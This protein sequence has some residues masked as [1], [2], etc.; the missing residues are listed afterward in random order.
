MQ[1][2]GMAEITGSWTSLFD[3]K[4]LQ[5]W[6]VQCVDA[7][8]N[9]TFWSVKHGAIVCDSMNASGHDYVWLVSDK[10][11]ADFELQLKVLSY[12]DSPGNSGIQIRSRFDE[13]TGW[14]DGPQVD[15]HP[16]TAWRSGLIYDE[17]RGHQR[18]IYPSLENWRIEPTQGP[19]QW[20]WNRND[21]N[22]VGIRCEG[23]KIIT[24]INGLVIANY[25][26]AGVLDDEAHRMR[27][28]GLN[29]FIALQLHKNDRL[30]IAFKD[31][32]I[33]PIDK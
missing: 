31:I 14:L 22:D 2:A 33:R 4:S 20:K 24:T 29:G 15:L 3:G 7:D 9:K 18:W 12:D 8:R 1:E 28:V 17:T 27:K 23:T 30:R 32:L 10:E 13:T 6:S 25:E 5:G 19:K 21:W 11:Y 16:P 26:G